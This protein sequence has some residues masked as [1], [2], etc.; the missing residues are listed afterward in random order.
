M[1]SL[2]RFVFSRNGIAVKT[3]ALEYYETRYYNGGDRWSRSPD[4]GVLKALL[5]KL[6]QHFGSRDLRLLDVGC[7]RLKTALA[8][9]ALAPRIHITAIDFAYSAIVALYADLPERARAAGIEFREADILQFTDPERFD[10][11]LD[12]GLLHHLIPD[13][14]PRYAAA[15]DRVI[16]RDGLFIVRS[17]HP[18]DGNWQEDYPGGHMRKG[19]HCYYH[20]LQSLTG[21]LY[22]V[23]G[24]GTS[25]VTEIFHDHIVSTYV[26]ER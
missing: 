14:W 16:L 4:E 10:V 24:G 23:V 22:G 8:W 2:D 26:F 18:R 19:Y 21:L 11:V 15:I 20:T 17:F 6:N 13:D 3:P 12:F 25:L 7:G 9:R 5:R 1:S